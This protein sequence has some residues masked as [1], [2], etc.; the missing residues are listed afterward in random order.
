M[1]L[2]VKPRERSLLRGSNPSE[3]VTRVTILWNRPCVRASRSRCPN[4]I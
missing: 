3:A 4:G 1:P 2:T